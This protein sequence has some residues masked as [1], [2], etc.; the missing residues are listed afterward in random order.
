MFP[1]NASF[2]SA[3]NQFGSSRPYSEA[4]RTFRF[5]VGTTF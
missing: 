3:I 1:N 4:A 2:Q 5:T